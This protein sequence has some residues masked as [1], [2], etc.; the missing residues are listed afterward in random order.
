MRKRR[1]T[2]V[3]DLQKKNEE[4]LKFINRTHKLVKRWKKAKGTK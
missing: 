4:W 2:D 3:E 1:S